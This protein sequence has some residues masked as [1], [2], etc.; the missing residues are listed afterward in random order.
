MNNRKKLVKTLNNIGISAS[1]N[2][3]LS[4]V[5]NKCNLLSSQNIKAFS[6]V[7]KK[8]SIVIHM[9]G[10]GVVKVYN[11][12]ESQTVELNEDTGVNVILENLSASDRYYFIDEVDGLIELDLH[13]NEIT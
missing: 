1:L 13:D 4:S 8:S 2:A 7:S 11:E 5:V 6:F 10:N 12:Y 9:K 3:S